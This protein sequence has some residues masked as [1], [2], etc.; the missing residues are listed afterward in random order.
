VDAARVADAMAAA[1]ARRLGLEG[2]GGLR[3]G[4]DADLS[5]VR[6]GGPWTLRRDDLRY[7]HPVSPYLGMRLTARVERTIL[8]GVTVHGPGAAGAPQGR[9]VT[10][11]RA[12]VA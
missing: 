12:A 9:L 5:L 3:P 7:R 4:Q 8:R 1:P 10:R 2:K 6:L 11:A